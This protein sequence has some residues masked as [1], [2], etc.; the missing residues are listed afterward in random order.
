[1]PLKIAD[2]SVLPPDALFFCDDDFYDLVA[3][4]AGTI[5]AKLLEIQGVRSVYSFLCTEDVFEI[6]TIS[7]SALNII[8]KSVCSEVDDKSFIVKPSCR[9]NIRYLYQL[10]HQKHEAHL[11][12]TASKS[13]RNRLL[14]SQNENIVTGNTQDSIQSRS[15]FSQANSTTTSSTFVSNF[16]FQSI[17]EDFAH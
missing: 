4:V 6:L 2:T 8:K 11:K 15:T 12:Q 10:L 1:M 13:K 7:C 3:K 5:E 9:S 14:M 17:S 16:R